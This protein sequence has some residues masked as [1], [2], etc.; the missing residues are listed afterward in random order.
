MFIPIIIKR[1]PH[2]VL[3]YFSS[4]T[5][6]YKVLLPSTPIE[7]TFRM[8]AITQ[9]YQV[10]PQVI[11]FII[12][13]KRPHHVISEKNILQANEYAD[14]VEK[15]LGTDKFSPKKIVTYIVC[16]KRNSRGAVVKLMDS[17]EQAGT[18]YIRTYSE[19]LTTS[20]KYHKEFIKQYDDFHNSGK[21]DKKS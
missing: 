16:G 15:H 19:L 5:N 7:I 17:L 4:K 14:F 13:L 18:I 21:D 20:Q 1:N 6:T 3:Y 11:L 12:E 2:Y 9:R 8:T 10:D